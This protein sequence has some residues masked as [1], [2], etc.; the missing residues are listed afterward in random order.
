MVLLSIVWER[1]TII[2]YKKTYGG[3]VGHITNNASTVV[4][5]K[6]WECGCFYIH[7][8]CGEMETLSVYAIDELDAREEAEKVIMRGGLGLKGVQC[9]KVQVEEMI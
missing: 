8:E 9:M 7:I 3:N 6:A 2:G 1:R 5:K 4:Q